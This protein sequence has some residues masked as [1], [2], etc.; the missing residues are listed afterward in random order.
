MSIFFPIFFLQFKKLINNKIQDIDEL[1]TY[2]DNNISIV[3]EIPFE[4]K[5]QNNEEKEIQLLKV[6]IY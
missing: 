6:L 2:L 5:N 1:R 4:E 3:G